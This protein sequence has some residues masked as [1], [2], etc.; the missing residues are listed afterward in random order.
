MAASFAINATVLPLGNGDLFWDVSVP[1]AVGQAVG[2]VLYGAVTGLVI[3][4][5]VRQAA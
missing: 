1:Q 4:R 2:G 5:I 3:A